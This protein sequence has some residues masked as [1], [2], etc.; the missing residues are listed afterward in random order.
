MDK[1]IPVTGASSGIGEGIAWDIARA[2]RHVFEAPEGMGTAEIS[3]RATKAT[4]AVLRMP[5]GIASASGPS[6]A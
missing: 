1:V 2:I 4:R 5:A 6:R 3:A